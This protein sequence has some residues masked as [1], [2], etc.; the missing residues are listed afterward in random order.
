MPLTTMETTFDRVVDYRTYLLR[1][2]TR[3]LTAEEA[4]TVSSFKKEIYGP[5][6]KLRELSGNKE[7]DLRSFLSVVRDALDIIGDSEAILL[8]IISVLTRRRGERC[9]Q[10][11]IIFREEMYSG[12]GV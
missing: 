6:P 4:I 10:R 12:G 11:E 8:R 7:I 1:N 3:T 2:K 5:H 9:S